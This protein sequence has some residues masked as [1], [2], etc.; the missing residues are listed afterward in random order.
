MDLL[1]YSEVYDPGKAE[2][3]DVMRVSMSSGTAIGG[4]E[5]V[6]DQHFSGTLDPNK[7][8]LMTPLVNYGTVML[9]SVA[10]QNVYGDTTQNAQVFFN[11]AQGLVGFRLN[12]ETWRLR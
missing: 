2:F 1:Y 6:T 9:D 5:L 3:V 12:G 4:A 11:A 10:Y 8:S 7:I